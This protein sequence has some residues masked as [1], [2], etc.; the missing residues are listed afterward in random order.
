MTKAVLYVLDRLQVFFRWLGADYEQLRTI[1]EVKFEMQNRKPATM[2]ANY[3]NNSNSQDVNNSFWLMSGIMILAGA[4][5]GAFV[6]FTDLPFY[7]LCVPFSYAMVMSMMILI[8]DFSSTLLDTTDNFVILPRPVSSQTVLLARLVHI[9]TYV[10]VTS[11][12]VAFFT[13]VFTAFRF[14]ILAFLAGIFLVILI[15]MLSV[16]LTSLLYMALMQFTTEERLKDIISYFQIAFTITISVGYQFVGRL[17]DWDM[18]DGSK[19]VVQT[20]HYFV[21]PLW[22]SGTVQW[23][24]SGQTQMLPFVLL[25][26]GV[27]VFCLWVLIYF[28]A[29]NFSKNIAA[30][31]SGDGGGG[32]RLVVQQRHGLV[33]WLANMATSNDV[34]KAVFELSWK[35]T[36]RD[37]KFKMRT[38]PSLGMFVPMLFLV[39]KDFL[40]GQQAADSHNYLIVCYIAQT[41]LTSFYS[42]T[43]YSEDFK[44][45]WVYFSTPNDHP[46]DVLMGNLKVVILK[47]YTPFY[48][49][50]T[51]L[52][53]SFWGYQTIDD[54]VLCYLLSISVTMFE[55]VVKTSFKLPFAKAPIQQQQGG[56]TAMMLA[57]FLLLPLL[58]FSHWGL[59]FIPYAI[60]VACILAGFLVYSLYKKYEKISWEQFDL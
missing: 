52:V 15:A 56:Q 27:P 50:I 58:G 51:A 48:L 10:L 8:T 38:Y 22:M 39:G 49:L 5:M 33:S 37:R 9:T 55:V 4:F 41:L 11:F 59:T 29:P 3:K 30:L 31:G 21:P 42:Q 19:I 57:L 26:V 16:F 6:F 23:V 24:V 17:F 43:F 40:K 46:R 34:E 7:A 20:W 36:G 2:F 45:A 18:A 25:A 53:V 32:E 47:F 13:L 54:L 1:V 44:A 28:L 14:G 60:S 12:S 35:I